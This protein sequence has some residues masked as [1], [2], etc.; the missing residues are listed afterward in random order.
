MVCSS[1]DKDLPSPDLKLHNQYCHT[2]EAKPFTLNDLF[3]APKPCPPKSLDLPLVLVTC[4]LLQPDLNLVK[5]HLFRMNETG[6][7]LTKNSSAVAG[8]F[9]TFLLLFFH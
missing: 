8:I 1:L 5:I 2:V 3:L 4:S 6:G 7:M 9:D